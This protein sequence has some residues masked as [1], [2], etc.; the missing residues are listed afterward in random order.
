MSLQMVEHYTR[1]AD[2]Q[3]LALNALKKLEAG[4]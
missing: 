1:A 2:Q 3:K 4:T